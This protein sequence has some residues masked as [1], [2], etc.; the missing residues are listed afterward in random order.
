MYRVQIDDHTSLGG[1]MGTERTWEI[2]SEYFS[3]KKESYA[4][5]Y[6]KAVKLAHPEQ[7]EWRKWPKTKSAFLKLTDKEKDNLISDLG[8]IGIKVSKISV[9][10]TRGKV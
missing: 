3:Q 9:H 7:S 5:A 8:N 1:P 10:R 2:A 6:D 4:Y